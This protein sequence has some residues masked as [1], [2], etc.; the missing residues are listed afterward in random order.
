MDYRFLAYEGL[1]A[2]IPMIFERY[3]YAPED[4]QTIAQ[5]LLT[6][7]LFGI[8]SHGVQRLSLYP[9]GIQ[10]GRIKVQAKTQVVRETPLSAVLDAGAGMGQ[11]VSRAAMEMAVRKAKTSGV[12]IVLVRN[13]N[14]FGI[15]GYY[16]LMAARQGLIG[17][18]LTNTQ[19][20][21]TPTFGK[22]P[23]LG[24][25]P[26]AFSVPAQP[27]PFHLDMS[28]SVV[29]GGKMEVYAKLDKPL[30]QGW[31]VDETGLVNTDAQAFVANRGQSRGGILPL[32]GAGELHGGHK[33]YGMAMMVEIMT[34]IMAGGVPSALV[35]KT[36]DKELCSH[37]FMAM[38]PAMFDSHP[39]AIFDRLSGFLDM[40]RSSEKAQDAQRIYIHGEKEFENQARVLQQGVPVSAKTYEE[41]LKV[42]RDRQ[43]DGQPYLRP[44]P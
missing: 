30:P 15:A 33:G 35:R 32:G 18:A 9:Y 36:P 42:C 6:A 26:I 16:S 38:D 4:A 21:V 19:A 28:T 39:Q 12:G 44:V 31:A 7:D 27:H 41:I 29:T 1:N 40:L 23:M 10:I 34:G 13:S 14:H 37:M 5:V 17:L 20:L 22:N 25:D 24:T 11:V 43:I 8:E 3:G 2:L